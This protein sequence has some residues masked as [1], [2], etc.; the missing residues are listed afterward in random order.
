[1]EGS[2]MKT[3]E[4]IAAMRAKMIEHFEATLAVAD[5]TRDGAA[6][7]LIESALDTIRADT[8]PGNLGLPPRVM[9]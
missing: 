7:Y 6:G 8:W 3:P 1:M 4:E 5:E 2:R 9:K